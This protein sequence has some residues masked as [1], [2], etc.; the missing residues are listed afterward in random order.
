M[1][2][3]DIED[4]FQFVGFAPYGEHEALI[5]PTTGEVIL[6]SDL[7]DLDPIPPEVDGSDQWLGIPHRSELLP[8]HRTVFTFVADHLPE[9]MALVEGF[10]SRPGAYGNFRNLLAQRGLLDRWHERDNE[11]FRQAI[12]QWCR[13]HEIEFNE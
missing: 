6:H 11:V 1:K 5:N 13:D 8:G 10:F 2:Y 9:D 4:A 3:S 7:S 12:L